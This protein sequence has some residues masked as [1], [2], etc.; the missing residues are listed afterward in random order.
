MSDRFANLKKLPAAPA[1]RLLASA[2]AKLEAKLEAPASAPV[3]TVLAE[4]Q[5]KEAW[6]DMLR[7]LAIS[8]PSR[9]CVWWACLAARDLVGENQ[10]HCLKAAETWVFEPNDTNREKVRMA[11]DNVDV[12]DDTAL[13]ATAALYAPGNMGSGDLAEYEAPPGA[14]SSCAF[15][16]NVISLS[17]AEDLNSWTQH[18]IDR[19]LDI[20]RGGSGKIAPATG[21]APAG[22]A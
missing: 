4:L 5:D 1:A 7:L 19:A 6:I 18:L 13:C 16:I 10:T 20:A 21:P 3:A 17:K 12:D 15:G 22:G 8:L 9:E 2:N 11:L 14:V